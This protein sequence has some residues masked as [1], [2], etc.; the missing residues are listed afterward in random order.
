MCS[1]AADYRIT[2]EERKNDQVERLED[3][4]EIGRSLEEA[5]IWHNSMALL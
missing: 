2:E 1:K 5:N 3:G 4:E